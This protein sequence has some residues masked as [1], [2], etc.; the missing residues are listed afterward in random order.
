MVYELTQQYTKEDGTF[1]VGAVL[2]DASRER[3]SGVPVKSVPYPFFVFVHLHKDGRW[4]TVS[5]L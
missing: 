1:Y 4:S 2:A 3:I 5:A